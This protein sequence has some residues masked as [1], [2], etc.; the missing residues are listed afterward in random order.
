MVTE[1][2]LEEGRVYPP[3]SSIRD[4][5]TKLAAH[6]IEYAYQEGLATTYPE[7]DDKLEFV[8]QNQFNTDY[9]SFI[10]VTYPWPG[11]NE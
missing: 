7:P 9:E 3:L 10:P 5:S 2:H 4:V 8:K 11:V 6:I 1:A